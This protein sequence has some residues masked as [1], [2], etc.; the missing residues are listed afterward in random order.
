MSS[1][2]PPPKK[3]INSF[4]QQFFSGQNLFW[5]RYSLEIQLYSTC[6]ELGTAQPQL[7]CYYLLVVSCYGGKAKS[8][9][10]SWV[11][12]R[13][14]WSL[15]KIQELFKWKWTQRKTTGFLKLYITKFQPNPPTQTHRWNLRQYYNRV[16][17]FY[18]KVPLAVHVELCR[19]LPSIPLA[20]WLVSHGDFSCD[21]TLSVNGKETLFMHIYMSIHCINSE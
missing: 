5:P 7:V 18:L 13:L 20:L 9:N 15:T 2:A 11:G 10:L 3:K 21:G 16:A 8:T 14:G 12:V 17:I 6:P 19:R 4:S 1:L